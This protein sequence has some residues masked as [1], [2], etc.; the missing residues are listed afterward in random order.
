[1]WELES[2]GTASKAAV[3]IGVG[4]ESVVNTSA[5]FLVKNNLQDLGAILLGAGALADDLDWED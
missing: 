1:L 2:N 5:L 3:D 4:I